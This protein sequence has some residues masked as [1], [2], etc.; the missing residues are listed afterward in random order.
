MIR[1][2]AVGDLEAMAE[3]NVTAWKTNYRGIIDDDFLWQRAVEDFIKKRKES[4]WITDNEIN[5]FVYEENNTIA[6]FVSGHKNTGKYDC[7]EKYDCEIK[8][9]YVR[10][11]YQGK[12]T[13]TKLLEFMKA[14]FKDAG[15]KNMIIWTI[16]NLENNNFYK[17]NGG[18]IKEEK[19]YE[20]GG[21]KYPG[22]GFVF[23][24]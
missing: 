4:N 18:E 10:V 16:R 1:Q 12:G 17:K 11:E 21:K 20:L 23:E 13:G 9:L 22:T 15:C 2:A 14:Q 8:G 6:G 3:I 5:I 7:E 19:A 24:L